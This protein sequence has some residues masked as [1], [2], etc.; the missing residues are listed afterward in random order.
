MR[1][2]HLFFAYLRANGYVLWDVVKTVLSNPEV[3]R[4]PLLVYTRRSLEN[5]GW[6]G[7]RRA[8]QIGV[9][10]WKRD[11]RPGYQPTWVDQKIFF[12]EEY[13]PE[14]KT[15]K[16]TIPQPRHLRPQPPLRGR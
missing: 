12:L 16:R 15:W 11:D 7:I 1:V 5:E 2:V 8:R 4:P 13:N 14:T 3:I 6:G 9:G 10:Y